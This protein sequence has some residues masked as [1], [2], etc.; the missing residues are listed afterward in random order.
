MA[1]ET[2]VADQRDEKPQ[3]EKV[4]IHQSEVLDN[5]DLMHEAFDGENYEHQMGVWEAAK[6]YPWACFW[7]FLMCFTIVS[8]QYFYIQSLRV[9]AMLIY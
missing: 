1:A 5:P 8:S 6:Q 4:D 3:S 2:D 7:A 9:I